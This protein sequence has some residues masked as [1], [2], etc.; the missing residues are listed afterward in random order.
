MNFPIYGKEWWESSDQSLVPSVAQRFYFNYENLVTCT[1]G[2]NYV[3]CLNAEIFHGV[4]NYLN[5]VNE[6]WKYWEV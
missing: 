4:L 1:T 3:W 2:S 6:N 5:F